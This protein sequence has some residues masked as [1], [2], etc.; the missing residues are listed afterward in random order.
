MNAMGLRGALCGMWVLLAVRCRRARRALGCWGGRRQTEQRGRRSPQCTHAAAGEEPGSWRAAWGEKKMNKTLKQAQP[1]GARMGRGAYGG[2]KS[3]APVS[4]RHGEPPKLS[5]LHTPSNS[6]QGA[7]TSGG[8]GLAPVCHGHPFAFTFILHSRCR[9][10]SEE[11]QL[12]I[13]PGE[14]SPCAGTRPEHSRAHAR[15][16]H[17]SGC[18]GGV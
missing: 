17:G 1:K 12:E 14:S 6:K 16:R 13:F 8:G 3:S 18:P 9:W 15:P 5:V 11:A 10:L 7:G 2:P 4:G